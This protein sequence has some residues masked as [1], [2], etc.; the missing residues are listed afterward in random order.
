MLQIFFRMPNGSHTTIDVEHPDTTTLH[1]LQKELCRRTGFPT[2]R[3]RFV[4]S[5]RQFRDMSLRVGE[6][7]WRHGCTV[8]TY[9]RWHGLGCLCRGCLPHILLRDGTSVGRRTTFWKL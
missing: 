1:D 9:V 8:H 3:Q 6:L 4:H 7:G 2:T 5:G